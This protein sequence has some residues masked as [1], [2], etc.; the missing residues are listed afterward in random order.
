MTTPNG[1]LSDGETSIRLDDA[2][3]R[4]QVTYQEHQRYLG[5]L[6]TFIQ[7]S[8]L[9]VVKKVRFGETWYYGTFADIALLSAF[10]EGWC[11]CLGFD[12]LGIRHQRG[13]PTP[14]NERPTL[15]P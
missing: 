8:A 3:F 13:E 15:I 11:M 6:N 5:A 4:A 7:A 12:D 14:A 9:R 2:H 1:Q 10:D